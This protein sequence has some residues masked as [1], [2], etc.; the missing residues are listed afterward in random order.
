MCSRGIN[1][2]MN[3]RLGIDIRKG[4]HQVVLINGQ[5]KESRPTRSCRR[6][7]SWRVQCTWRLGERKPNTAYND[8]MAAAASPFRIVHTVCSHDCP[9][10][11]AVLVTV[12]EEGRAIK[13][14][15]RSHRSRSRRDF[16]AAKWP[17]ISIASTRPTAF[18]IRC[19]A[20]PAWPKGRCRAAASTKPSSASAGTKRSTP[21]PRG[22]SRSATGTVPNR[23]CPTATPAPS[24]CSATD[25]W[26]AA[27]FTAWAP[28]SS[29]APFAPRPAA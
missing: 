25:R 3:R 24:A 28:A 10:S 18:F 19:D 17:S 21:S 9:D 13:V 23:F 7:N 20:S 1:E 16:S 8:T 5:S 27:S 14:A 26:I 6:G 22:S 4:I 2:H 11:C 12:N 29:T 15:G